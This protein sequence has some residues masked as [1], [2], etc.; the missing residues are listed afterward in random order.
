M[1]R[2]EDLRA[3][4]LTSDQIAAVVE[5]S[6]HR[7][8]RQNRER[9]QRFRDRRN[10]NSVTRN[11][12]NVTAVTLPP[13]P[14]PPSLNNPPPLPPTTLFPNSNEFGA[15][16][17][18]GPTRAEQERELFR[19]GK[20]VLGKNAGGMISALLKSREYDLALSRAAIE[21]ASTKH[22]PREYVAA[23]IK[24]GGARPKADRQ[25]LNGIPGII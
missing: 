6:E 7:E 12:C 22:D 25:W 20:Q 1:I 10:A 15:V 3:A 4:G 9:Q 19:R 17:E 18:L 14:F 24:G 11:E 8:L 13:P 2:I 5:A 16:I 21:T 23:L